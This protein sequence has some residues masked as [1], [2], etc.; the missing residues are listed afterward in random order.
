MIEIYYGDGKGKTTAAEG[1]AIRAAGHGIPVLFSQ[2]LKDDSSGEIAV[3]RKVDGIKVMHP[4]AFYGFVRQ[5]TQEQKEQTCIEYRDML[6]R[7]KRWIDAIMK[8]DRA[9]VQDGSVMRDG[10]AEQDGMT[11]QEGLSDKSGQDCIAGLVVMDEVLH[12]CYYEL[13][14]EQK[15]IDFLNHLP[16]CIELVMTGRN[17]SQTLLACAD[18]ISEVKKIRHPFDRGIQAR[19]GVEL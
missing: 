15:L 17:P 19:L 7:T 3:L 5:M 6:H 2:F 10:L 11:T 13:L 12:A 16:Q 18:Y 4:A 9:A 1:L 14:P 8:G